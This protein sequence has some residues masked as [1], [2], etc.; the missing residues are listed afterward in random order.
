MGDIEEN[1]GGSKVKAMSVAKQYQAKAKHR[2]FLLTYTRIAS[3]AQIDVANYFLAVFGL[4][5]LTTLR[6]LCNLAN[7]VAVILLERPLFPGRACHPKL[8]LLNPSMTEKETRSHFTDE[9]KLVVD[10]C[11]N[12]TWASCATA[13][14]LREWG[15]SED[16]KLLLNATQK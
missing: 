14:A 9:E 5:C 16:A 4:R 15:E 1:A 11:K 12:C 3:Q 6:K 7:R 2:P 10:M 13:M 8:A